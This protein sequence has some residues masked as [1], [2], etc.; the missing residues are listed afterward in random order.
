MKP[1][2][3]ILFI[4][5]KLSVGGA[6]KH[7]LQLIAGLS[8]LGF[9]CSLAVLKPNFDMLTAHHRQ[10]LHRLVSL[11]VKKRLDWQSIEE[12]SGFIETQR[13]DSIVCVDMYPM[14]YGYF[15]GKR[16]KRSCQL[17][18][19]LH[20]TTP[21]NLYEKLKIGVY[22]F[23]FRRFCHVVFVSENQRKYWLEKQGLKPKSSSTIL[24]GIDVQR[25]SGEG[26][27]GAA[28]TVRRELNLSQSSLVIGV[29]AALR[30]HKGHLLL[31]ESL[32]RLRNR[33]VDAH[34]LI[35]GDGVERARIE[36]SVKQLG[37]TQHVSLVGSQSD[38]RPYVSACDCMVVPSTAVETFSLSIL[39]SMAMAK[40]VV[41][42]R[43]G[44]ADE[45]IDHGISG[46]LFEK[47]D[48]DGLVAQLL[49]LTNEKVRQELG[50]RAHRKVA[51][52]FTLDGMI[53]KYA[54]LLSRGRLNLPQQELQR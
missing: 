48:V 4:V 28:D 8:S 5:N 12:L 34:L 32:H 47:K 25:Y 33:G 23:F 30:P 24:N 40:P 2:S 27:A 44:G 49:T 35:I 36:S 15:A 13:I 50:L 16:A 42:S 43:I 53:A 17:V 6:E 37:L 45:Q 41:S 46:L 26:L 9:E 11:N 54:R 3:R 18:E 39:E 29:C 51:Q 31:V 20:F 14:L 19:V 1:H 10:K 21:A 22:R 7:T 52:N 38:V